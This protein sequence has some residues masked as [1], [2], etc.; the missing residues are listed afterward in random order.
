MVKSIS[1]MFLF[2]YVDFVKKA[3]V[4]EY[5]PKLL[6]LFTYLLKFLANPINN[7]CNNNKNVNNVV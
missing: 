7:V 3:D 6:L 4:E 5:L 1:F 2:L